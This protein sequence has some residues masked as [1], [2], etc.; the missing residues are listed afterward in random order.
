[1]RRPAHIVVPKK[2][3]PRAVDRNRAKRRVRAALRE[4]GPDAPQ[5]PIRPSPAT[6][7]LPFVELKRA[8]RSRVR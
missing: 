4:L 7:R 1:M 3:F 2:L 6:A 5:G 8:L